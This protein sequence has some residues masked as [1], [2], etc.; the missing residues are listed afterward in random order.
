MK[1]QIPVVQIRVVCSAGTYIRTLC[2]DIGK[3]LGCGAAMKSLQRTRVGSFLIEDALTLDEVKGLVHN[4]GL[5]NNIIP[6]DA[7][8]NNLRAISVEDAYFKQLQNGNRLNLEMIHESG[9]FEDDERA[10]IYSG[11]GVFFGIYR[12]EHITGTFN[13]VKMFIT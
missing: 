3:I 8:F 6:V 10:R 13:P 7:M 12:Y 2:D 1:I 4:G 5:E 9:S 11:Q